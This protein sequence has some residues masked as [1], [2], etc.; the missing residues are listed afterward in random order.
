MTKKNKAFSVEETIQGYK[1]RRVFWVSG[2]TVFLGKAWGS[3]S[4]DNSAGRGVSP[5]NLCPWRS[6][7]SCVP[8]K[9]TLS[10]PTG[11]SSEAAKGPRPRCSPLAAFCAD[12]SI[13][14][15]GL[16]PDSVHA[17]GITRGE[18]E[19]GEL[20]GEGGGG[21]VVA[22][23]LNVLSF[24]VLLQSLPRSFAVIY[25]CSDPIPAPSGLRLLRAV[26][27]DT[28]MS[29]FSMLTASLLR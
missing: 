24:S 12:P 9:G 23:E 16:L 7:Q 14:W 13:L 8:S 15:P 21:L 28:P 6:A 22:H 19:E 5:A 10:I 29:G 4:L 27:S 17:A 3:F 20:E 25:V 2:K 18:R 1:W 11:S 26:G